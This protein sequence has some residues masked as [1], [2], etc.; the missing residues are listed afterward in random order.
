MARDPRLKHSIY[1]YLLDRKEVKKARPKYYTNTMKACQSCGK[2]W[3]AWNLGASKG[4]EI[5]SDFPT[6]GLKRKRCIHCKKEMKN[7]FYINIKAG[8]KFSK[9]IRDIRKITDGASGRSLN[10]DTRNELVSSN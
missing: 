6:Y 9:R 3:E 1:T 7:A 5:Y 4:T 10:K 8:Y 2:A